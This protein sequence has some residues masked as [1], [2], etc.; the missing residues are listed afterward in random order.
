MPE[1][2]QESEIKFNYTFTFP[3]GRI[4]EFDVRLKRDSMSI[5][6]PNGEK[7]PEWA[8]LKEFKCPHCPLDENEIECR[9]TT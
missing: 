7:A 5:I 3:A 2:A 4:K 6:R 9:L 8:K 1:K